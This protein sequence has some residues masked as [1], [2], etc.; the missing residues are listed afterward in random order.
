MLDEFKWFRPG[1]M[2]SPSQ[3]PASAPGPASPSST[4]TPSATPAPATAAAALSTPPPV[5]ATPATPPTPTRTTASS[6]APSSPALPP[7][8]LQFPLSPDSTKCVFFGHDEVAQLFGEITGQ[9]TQDRTLPE[10]PNL[11]RPIVHPDNME[12]MRV[13]L[14]TRFFS[15]RNLAVFDAKAKTDSSFVWKALADFSHAVHNI[16]M[17]CLLSPYVIYSLF[18]DC[19]S[20]LVNGYDWFWKWR[21]SWLANTEG[22]SKTARNTHFL[23]W[24]TWEQLTI[25]VAG[26]LGYIQHRVSLGK[27]VSLK[28]CSQSALEGFFG[29]A[30]GLNNGHGKLTVGTLLRATA[31][32]NFLR[33]D[34]VSTRKGQTSASSADSDDSSF[35]M[36][37]TLKKRQA[38]SRANADEPVSA[39]KR[40]KTVDALKKKVKFISQL[41]DTCDVSE[42]MKQ[43]NQGA[44]K[45]L[46]GDL[47][48]VA[49][50]A[51]EVGMSLPSRRKHSM[52]VADINKELLDS[53]VFNF[54]WKQI[55][56]N[57]GCDASHVQIVKKRF[58]SY[59]VNTCTKSYLGDINDPHKSST[60][61][62][63]RQHAGR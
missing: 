18:D 1:D 22:M 17:Q 8:T 62:Q 12:K 11:T 20:Y 14:A 31:C 43:R 52:V 44:L 45:F 42:V 57:Q 53:E 24:Q 34:S 21:E 63:I 56:A 7:K 26:I 15:D 33:E 37:L 19:V 48:V 23:A 61:G 51:L 13:H 27:G 3:A 50:K 39:A 2:D 46:Q 29:Y 36:Q 28:R 30:R 16:Y 25:T 5:P 58:I 54:R 35:T 41:P 40:L 10:T 55:F 47:L 59:I 9:K 32:A 6:K 4:A 49:Q 38:P 60:G